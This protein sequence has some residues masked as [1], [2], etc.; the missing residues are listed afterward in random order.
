[1]SQPEETGAPI[2]EGA[3]TLRTA[4][5]ASLAALAVCALVIAAGAGESQVDVPGRSYTVAALALAAL[6]IG[7]RLIANA[8]KTASHTSVRLLLA[9]LALAVGI[10][11]VGLL[12]SLEEG[13]WKTGLFY[14][15]AGGMLAMRPPTAVARPASED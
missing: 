9:S 7:G 6:S 12:V 3:G 1:M 14:T 5:R 8:P 11:V 2:A 15:L 4:H 13:L 10:G